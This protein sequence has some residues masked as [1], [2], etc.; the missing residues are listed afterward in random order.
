M[1]VRGT[2]LNRNPLFVPVPTG[3]WYQANNNNKKLTMTLGASVAGFWTLDHWTIVNFEIVPCMHRRA[4]RRL[5]LPAVTTIHHAHTNAPSFT[6]VLQAAASRAWTRRASPHPKPR[7]TINSPVVLCSRSMSY[8]RPGP[9][10]KLPGDKSMA[11]G[12]ATR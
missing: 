5:P 8:G 7:T 3:D 12:F 4:L 11:M 9:S 6:Q 1:Y 10:R 2:P